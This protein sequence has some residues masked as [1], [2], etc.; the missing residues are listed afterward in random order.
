M[1]KRKVLATL[2]INCEVTMDDVLK[3]N[4]E[5]E[6][7]RS[8]SDED[9]GNRLLYAFLNPIIQ[10]Y[11]EPENIGGSWDMVCEFEGRLSNFL[12]ETDD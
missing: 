2:I 1:E 10:V 4:V 5:R 7:E 6:Y 3:V 12:V 8:M 11:N 9:V